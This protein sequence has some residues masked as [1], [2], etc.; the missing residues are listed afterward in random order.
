[1]VRQILHL[2]TVPQPDDA[3]DGVAIAVCHLQ[4]ARY[5]SLGT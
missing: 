1:M 5:R 3:A 4:S 2:D